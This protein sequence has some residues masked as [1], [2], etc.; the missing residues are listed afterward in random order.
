MSD[1]SSQNVEY[2]G[3]VITPK[4][5]QGHDDLW[6]DGYQIF[7]GGASVSS[8][9]NTESAHS[10]LHA[11]YDSSVEFAKIEV[12]NLVALTG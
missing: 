7:K 8:R 11:A 9:T 2:R 6:H 3:Y 10:T 5:V 12:D 1:Q 4:P